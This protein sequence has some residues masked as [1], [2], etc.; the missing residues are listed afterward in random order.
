M[1]IS[2]I[3]SELSQNKIIFK[4]L[5][6]NLPPETYLWR[7]EEDKWNLLE[8]L[9]H[10]YDEER[11]DFRARIKSVL[12]NP[13]A[14]LPPIDPAGWVISRNYSSENFEQKLNAFLAERDNSIQWLN[15]LENPNWKNAHKHQKFG[16]LSAKMFLY[17]WLAHD[18]LHIRQITRVKYEYFKNLGKVRFD[19]AG[20]W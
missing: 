8:I 5:F 19:Y 7:E 4:S 6:E 14:L 15:S 3:V 11:E 16:P 12:E 13:D 17:N 2:P 20:R 18:Y 10:L 9:C 1:D